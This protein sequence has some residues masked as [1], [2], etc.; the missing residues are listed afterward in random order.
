MKK[1]LKGFLNKIQENNTGEFTDGFKV[2]KNIRGGILLSDDS[3][4]NKNAC[5]NPGTCSGT[6]SNICTNNKCGNASNTGCTNYGI[7]RS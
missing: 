7:C 5:E 1:S 3:N 4:T 2:F 6:N